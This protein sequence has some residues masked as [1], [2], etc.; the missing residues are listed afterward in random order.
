MVIDNEEKKKKWEYATDEYKTCSNNIDEDILKDDKD[1]SYFEKVKSSDNVLK[2]DECSPLKEKDTSYKGEHIKRGQFC[3]N[4]NNIY[5]DDDNNNIYNDDDNNNIYNDDDNNIYSCNNSCVSTHFGNTKRSDDMNNAENK[6]KKNEKDLFYDKV[7]EILNRQSDNDDDWIFNEDDEKKNKN[8][9]GNDNRY[10][11]NDL[12]NNNNNDNNKYDY[13]FYDDEKKNKNNDGDDN[14]YD[15]N[16]LQNNNNNKYDYNHLQNNNNNK[17]DYNFDDDEKK[18]SHTPFDFYQEERQNKAYFL[19]IHTLNFEAHMLHA[20][21]KKNKYRLTKYNTNMNNMI[22]KYLYLYKKKKSLKYKHLKEQSYN[23]YTKHK[24]Y[25]YHHTNE[26]EKKKNTQVD[27]QKIYVD[28]NKGNVSPEQV[29]HNKIENMEKDDKGKFNKTDQTN[30]LLNIDYYNKNNKYGYITPDNDDGD[31]YN[32]DNDNDDNYNDDNDNDDNYNDDNYNDDNYNDDNYN[33]DNY[34]DEKKKKKNNLMDVHF[35]YMEYFIRKKKL[36]ELTNIYNKYIYNKDNLLYLKKWYLKNVYIL[37]SKGYDESNIRISDPK[38]IYE[39]NNINN[40]CSDIPGG[41]NSD[42]SYYFSPPSIKTYCLNNYFICLLSK[43]NEII[44]I[45]YKFINIHNLIFF[46]E[47]NNIDDFFFKTEGPININF[48]YYKYPHYAVIK[49]DLWKNIKNIKNIHINDKNKLCV[50][51]SNCVYVFEIFL[52]NSKVKYKYLYNYIEKGTFLNKEN[53]ISSSLHIKEK[54]LLY[55][56]PY[57]IIY[58]NNNKNIFNSSIT[59]TKDIK[60][61]YKILNTSFYKNNI[62]MVISYFNKITVFK[63]EAIYFVLQY[64]RNG[65][66]VS[67][68]EVNEKKKGENEMNKE[69]NKMNEE[70]NKMNEEVNKMD[71]EVNKMNEEVNKMDEEVNK[72]NKEVNKMNK[73]VNKMNKEANEM[74]KE[75][76]EMNKE[77]N[78]MNKDEENEKYEN[79]NYNYENNICINTNGYDKKG[80]DEEKYNL[81]DDYISY[82]PFL[83]ILENNHFC[84]AYG[85]TLTVFEYVSKVVIKYKYILNHSIYFFKS[86]DNNIII[87]YDKYKLYV[88][89]IMLK[90]DSNFC[91]LLLYEKKMNNVTSRVISEGYNIYES[92]DGFIQV[93]KKNVKVNK[94]DKIANFMFSLFNQDIVLNE[95]NSK[96]DVSFF[97]INLIYIYVLNNDK[98]DII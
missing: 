74:N 71:K 78:E 40:N 29:I 51:T 43:N 10:D 19:N 76:N 63:N 17:Y 34:N 8:N 91:I 28:D 80:E 98:V 47:N 72:M 67:E 14:K 5:S 6:K 55:F 66:V 45:G 27:K 53:N 23:N 70:V 3:K 85:K 4:K 32:D 87:I 33:D 39:Y 92:Y 7:D 22:Y 94:N 12:Q 73:E 97:Y 2:Y 42:T 95:Q 90:G 35:L 54:K 62:Y 48:N 75:T 84:A 31:D 81:K 65:D 52:S 25:N 37:N 41:E 46:K 96:K 60:F 9:D 16:H 89:Q 58:L 15:Y 82:I 1:V 56:T 88:Y 36:T 59:I 13:N 61:K 50:N 79:H 68:Q 20:L 24:T 69:V 64:D 44:V 30:K 86:C 11:Y 21:L 83:G 93:N 38:K 57:N 26:K 77:A 18:K 49:N